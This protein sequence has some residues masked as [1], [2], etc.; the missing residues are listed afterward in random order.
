MRGY[1]LHSPVSDHHLMMNL[2]LTQVFWE[3]IYGIIRL[4]K[5][6]MNNEKRRIASS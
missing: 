4:A 3:A 6:N 2:I 1:H 5:L